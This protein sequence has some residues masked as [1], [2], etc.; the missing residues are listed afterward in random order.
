MPMVIAHSGTGS[1]APNWRRLSSMV[2]AVSVFT[3]V[4]EARLEAGSLTPM[5]PQRPMPSTGRSMPPAS[6]MRRS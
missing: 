4:R 3:R 5:C 1:P 6:A 2:A